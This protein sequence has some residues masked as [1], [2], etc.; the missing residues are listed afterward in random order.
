MM[1][2]VESKLSCVIRKDKQVD[3]AVDNAEKFMKECMKMQE[4]L[5][6]VKMVDT[7]VRKH[8]E[9][10]NVVKSVM[11]FPWATA[12]ELSKEQTLIDLKWMQ[13][14]G[15]TTGEFTIDGVTLRVEVEPKE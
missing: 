5:N 10:A 8:N 14:I 13:E 4:L 15:A 2:E 9:G 7:V 11:V 6:A 3:A 12:V 1:D